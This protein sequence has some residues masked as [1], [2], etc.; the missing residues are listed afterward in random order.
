MV[1]YKFAG[2]PL[3]NQQIPFLAKRIINFI[4]KVY[5]YK[6][7]TYWVRLRLTKT[8][9]VQQ[10]FQEIPV[11]SN[12]NHEIL[13]RRLDTWE[14]HDWMKVPLIQEGIL[15]EHEEGIVLIER[16]PAV[17]KEI[18]EAVQR[19][20]QISVPPQEKISP[21]YRHHTTQEIRYSQPL[22]CNSPLCQMEYRLKGRD[23]IVEKLTRIYSQERRME[24]QVISGHISVEDIIGFRLVCTTEKDC[25][26]A[27]E[28]FAGVPPLQ[29]IQTE[30]FLT[31]PRESGYRAIH[32]T[33]RWQGRRLNSRGTVVKVHYVPVTDFH[34]QHGH[35]NDAARS[36]NCYMDCKLSA[37]HEQGNHLILVVEKGRIEKA[38]PT[39][40]FINN[41]KF[42]K[43]FL[44]NIE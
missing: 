30:D 18:S 43:Y 36:R 34:Q 17:L 24:S 33:F 2:V 21:I 1:I 32:D 13:E 29:R 38:E 42:G 8:M 9:A 11:Y 27:R 10:A 40:Q 16:D 25:Q 37:P 22:S 39:M 41:G 23:S 12:V 35:P 19:A 44:M 4:Y 6:K 28:I 5:S 20:F 31:K 3:L 7:V 15:P 14:K 26:K